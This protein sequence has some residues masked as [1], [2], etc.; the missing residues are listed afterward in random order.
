MGK[1][2][3]KKAGAAAGA[4]PAAP[5]VETSLF[6]PDSETTNSGKNAALATLLNTAWRPL[7]IVRVDRIE[8]GDR[9]WRVV[10]REW[11]ATR[12]VPAA[13]G[14]RPA[15]AAGSAAA[16]PGGGRPPGREWRGASPR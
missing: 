1:P 14:A 16:G 7:A 15:A 2:R 12:A 8:I 10:F 13:A 11:P 5:L 6:E 9:G 3:K 4:A